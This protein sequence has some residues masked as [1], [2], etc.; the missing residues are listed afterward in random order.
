[1]RCA[2]PGW[3]HSTLVAMAHPGHTA[4]GARPWG[5]TLPFPPLAAPPV[6]SGQHVP[7]PSQHPLF[8]C[9]P[10]TGQQGTLTNSQPSLSLSSPSPSNLPRS[11]LSMGPTAKYSALLVYRAGPGLDQPQSRSKSEA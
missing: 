6:A 10:A 11:E 7:S 1:M 5:C 3:L 4:Q 8:L 9:R 2:D